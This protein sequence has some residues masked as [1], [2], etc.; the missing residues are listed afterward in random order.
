MKMKLS[1]EEMLHQWRMRRALEPLRS[2][3]VVQRADGIDLDPLLKM[4]MR[5]WYLNLI[6]T[7][8]I[9]MLAP[10]DICA[11]VALVVKSDGSAEVALPERCRRVVEVRLEEWDR[12]AHI[13]KPGSRQARCQQSRYSRGGAVE[14][15]AIVENGSMRLYSV[16]SSAPKLVKLLCVVEPE[17]GYYTFDERAL[18]TITNYQI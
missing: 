11:D 4:E 13:V 17:D 15:V 2:D 8:P 5:D 16:L 3:C 14:P 9:E 10:E 1:T 7:A 6:D 18:A 12:A